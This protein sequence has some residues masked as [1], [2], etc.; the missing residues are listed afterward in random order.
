MFS[1]VSIKYNANKICLDI[2]EALAT[3]VHPSAVHA[4]SLTIQDLH[5]PPR[6]SLR[7][8]HSRVSLASIKKRDTDRVYS[9]SMK[10][11][12]T[13]AICSFKQ[14]GTLT[15]HVTSSKSEEWSRGCVITGISQLPTLMT[16]VLNAN[17]K[18]GI[19]VQLHSFPPVQDFVLH[20]T[21]DTSISDNGAIQGLPEFIVKS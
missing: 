17:L 5:A 6:K 13:P 20:A 9:E 3:G 19:P 12:L 2:L 18:V 1:H 15:W 8:C 4:K 11:W 21:C 7:S 16:L 14:V 10:K